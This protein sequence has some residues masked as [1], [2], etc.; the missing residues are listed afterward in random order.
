[1]TPV[2]LVG[3][4]ADQIR[5]V[6]YTKEE[7]SAV[8]LPG[9]IGILRAGNIRDAGISLDDLVYV[10]RRRVADE[11]MVRKNDVLVATSS[12]SIDV[13]G[14]AAR[15]TSDLG[16]AFGAFCKVLRPRSGIEP[17][18]FAY[19]FRT[20][21]YRDTVSRLA[22]GVNINNLR[23]EHLDNLS[24]VVP[25]DSEQRRIADMLD[26][27]QGALRKS[28]EACDLADRLVRS[29]FLEL[30]GDPA[31][32]PRRWPVGALGDSVELFAGNS[33]PAGVPYTGQSGGFLLLKV[34][35]MNT[36]GNESDIVAAREWAPNLP[37]GV[38]VAPAGAVVI[39]KRGGAIATNKKR[40]LT[41]PAALD[42]NLMAIAPAS[43]LEL[44]YLRHWFAEV[45][46]S[47]LSNG[48]TVPQLNKKDLYPLRIPLP[49]PGLQERFSDLARRIAR[50]R[51]RCDAAADTAERLFA[52]LLSRSFAG[53]GER[54]ARC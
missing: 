25:R 39:P 12:G 37:A 52:T 15:A 11:Q 18:Y 4:L 35:D 43:G 50:M 34:G 40:V 26:R 36:A 19:F 1:M 6:T 53:D 45:D 51:K 2:R 47:K 16:V 30:F 38:T 27:A 10:P 49:P 9:T 5:G 8:P 20:T 14:K 41:R 48:S 23:N 28:L 7:A 32:N 3:D 13:V 17:R 21:H 29:T 31:T 24:L 46:L 44:S 54:S 42:P 22:A 33:L